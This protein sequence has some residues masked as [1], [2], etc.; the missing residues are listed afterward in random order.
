MSQTVVASFG[1]FVGLLSAVQVHPLLHNAFHPLSA[2]L[3]V[4]LLQLCQLL[5]Q[6]ANRFLLLA[7][8]AFCDFYLG[9]G[10][11]PSSLASAIGYLIV[12]VAIVGV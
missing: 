8:L 1:G 9:L 2:L 11:V 7:H 4:F 12:A 3:A 5:T 6:V 10:F